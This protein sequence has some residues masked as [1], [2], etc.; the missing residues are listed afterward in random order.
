[1]VQTL[2]RSEQPSGGSSLAPVSAPL[3][4]G[5][6]EKLDEDRRYVVL[7]LG[8]ALTET[9]S[10]FSGLHCRIDI[11]DLADDLDALNGHVEESERQEF[12]ESLVAARR[13]EPADLV[14]CWDLL[15]YLERP[16]LKTLMRCVA[17]RARPGAWVHAL[18]AYAASEM[19]SR[20]NHYLPT[21]D[22]TLCVVARTTELRAAPRYTMGDLARYMPSYRKDRVILLRNG[23]QEFLFRT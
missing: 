1:M 12:A 17:D 19:P 15:N 18:M 9:V 8:P 6:L 3:F 11:V 4:R 14:L 20:P 10:A 22:H 5:L 21:E 2:G 13:D 23:M 16:A 7:D